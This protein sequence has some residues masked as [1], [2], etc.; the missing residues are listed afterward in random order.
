MKRFMPLVRIGVG[1]A[2]GVITMKANQKLGVVIDQ[3][4][5]TASIFF[6]LASINFHEGKKPKQPKPQDAPKS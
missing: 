5:L 1:V 6:A 4:A 2:A 3:E